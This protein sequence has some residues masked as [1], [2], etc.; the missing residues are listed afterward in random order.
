[1]DYI[2]YQSCITGSDAKRLSLVNKELLLTARRFMFHR[3]SVRVGRDP[4]FSI[5]LYRRNPHLV[6]IART[7]ELNDFDPSHTNLV[8]DLL[9]LFVDNFNLRTFKITGID[10]RTSLSSL[11]L[12]VAHRFNIIYVDG[13]TYD[14]VQMCYLLSSVPGVR[15]LYIGG[16]TRSR[17]C[18]R[19]LHQ[20]PEHVSAGISELDLSSLEFM[21]YRTEIV[22]HDSCITYDASCYF[23]ALLNSERFMNVLSPR[24]HLLRTLTLSVQHHSCDTTQEVLSKVGSS[25][26]FLGLSYEY[27]HRCKV[28]AGLSLAD[29]L[30]LQRLRLNL[31]VYDATSMLKM[32]PSPPT[33]MSLRLIFYITFG[34]FDVLSWFNLRCAIKDVMVRRRDLRIQLHTLFHEDDIVRGYVDVV[35][36]VI[37]TFIPYPGRIQIDIYGFVDGK[38]GPCSQFVSY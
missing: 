29:C 8:V 18:Q 6:N 36:G 28:D 37:S 13:C 17:L 26:L 11:I 1:M 20:Y 7:F 9:H 35:N 22:S 24:L 27:D 32:L 31:S 12:K 21:S 25:I 4:Q 14:D 16:T 23:H 5:D 10:F 30:S 34:Q 38:I 2:G 15:S 19:T 33:L 3:V